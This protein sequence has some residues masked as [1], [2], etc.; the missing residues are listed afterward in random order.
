MSSKIFKKIKY[1]FGHPDSSK[2]YS[3][4]AEGRS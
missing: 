3:G 4:E 2:G 1:F